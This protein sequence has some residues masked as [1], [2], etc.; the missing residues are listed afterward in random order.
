MYTNMLSIHLIIRHFDVDTTLAI[1]GIFFT[2]LTGEYYHEKSIELY[3]IDESPDSIELPTTPLPTLT[4][5]KKITSITFSS[6]PNGVFITD[7]VILKGDEFIEKGILVAGAPESSYCADATSAAIHVPPGC[8]GIPFTSL[9]TA[10]PNNINSCNCIPIAITFTSLVRQVTLT[11]AG[12]NV[13]YTMKAFDEKGNLL[14]TVQKDA[15]INVSRKGGTFQITFSS[16][17]DNINRVTFGRQ[18]AITAIKEIHYEQ[19]HSSTSTTFGT[20]LEYD[21]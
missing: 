6:F 7:D 9:S 18:T 1:I 8:S 21:T 16:T 14:G 20:V 15:D 3:K 17:S 10:L 13:T 2:I 11:F 12:A 19:M 5:G 4:P